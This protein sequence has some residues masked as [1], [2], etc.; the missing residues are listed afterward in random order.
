MDSSALDLHKSFSSTVKMNDQD[1]F[2]IKKQC[3]KDQFPFLDPEFLP[4]P[5]SL[6]DDKVDYQ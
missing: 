1:F 5:N 2:Q 6:C 3:E 4:E